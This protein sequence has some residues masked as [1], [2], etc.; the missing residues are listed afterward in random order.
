MLEPQAATQNFTSECHRHCALYGK[1]LAH[2]GQ[3]HSIY[4]T[5]L[6]YLTE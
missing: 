6:M 2:I 5:K 1:A 3:L 4:T